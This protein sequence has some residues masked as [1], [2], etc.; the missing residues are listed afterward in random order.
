MLF[1]NPGSGIGVA[2]EKAAYREKAITWPS[3][4]ETCDHMCIYY[5][6]I[7]DSESLN[8]AR[9]KRIKVISSPHCVCARIY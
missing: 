2:E 1:C 9:F 6:S 4:D 3:N 5:H 7:V 8:K